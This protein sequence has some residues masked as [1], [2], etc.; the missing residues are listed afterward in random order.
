[1]A[2]SGR[3]EIE[4]RVR[5]GEQLVVVRFTASKCP[6]CE[7]LEPYVEAA[8]QKLQVAGAACYSVNIDEDAELYGF[9]KTK[10][11]VPGTPTVLAY[12]PRA[13]DGRD[14]YVPDHSVIGF[15][16]DDLRALVSECLR[17]L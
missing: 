10:R 11:M 1:M 14:W 6:P 8:F 7:M 16:P 4:S 3:D 9:L 17:V 2:A 12:C 13:R 5:Q 15:N